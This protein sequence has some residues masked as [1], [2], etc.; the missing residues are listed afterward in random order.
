MKGLQIYKFD[1][2]NLSFKKISLIFPTVLILIVFI[3][4]LILGSKVWRITSTPHI[5]E[6]SELLIIIDEAENESV[7]PKKIYEFLVETRVKYPEIVWSQCAI[8]TGFKS[9]IC[10]E[11]NNFFGM[12]KSTLRPHVQNGENRGHAAY[13]NWKLS[14]IDYAIWQSSVGLLKIKSEEKYFEYLGQSYAEDPEYVNKVK[15]VRDNFK[16]YL[17]KYNEA[18]L[19]TR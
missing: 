4:G 19:E 11:N 3:L 15:K 12:K 16:Y 9:S 6:A 18:Y 5:V 7:T 14:V 10:R 2:L 1:A 17:E 13:R 8:E